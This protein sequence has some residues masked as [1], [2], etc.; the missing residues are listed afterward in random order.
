MTSVVIKTTRNTPL[1]SPIDKARVSDCRSM[2]MRNRN[3]RAAHKPSNVA[4]TIMPK[5]PIWNITSNAT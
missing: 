4:E 5:P 1:T 2:R 3:E